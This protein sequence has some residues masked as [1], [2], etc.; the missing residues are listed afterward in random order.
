M[1]IDSDVPVWPPQGRQGTFAHAPPR[2]RDRARRRAEPGRPVWLPVLVLLALVLPDL[3]R[4][5]AAADSAGGVEVETLASLAT[6]ALPSPLFFGLAHLILPPGVASETA[7]T[8]G[9]RLFEVQAGS[10]TVE[11]AGGGVAF[12]AGTFGPT[13]TR[14]AI[15]VGE[16]V[17]LGRGDRLALGPH[18]VRRVRNDGARPVVYLDAALFSPGTEPVTAAFTTPDGITFQLLAGAIV[19]AIPTGAVEIALDRVSLAP[20]AELPT[21][22][23]LGAAIA[24]VES[25]SLWLVPTAGAVEYARAAAA[26]PS[27]TVGRMR[28]VALGAEVTMTAGASVVL[29]PG[30]AVA[31]RNGRNAPVTLLVLEVRPASP[32]ST[33]ATLPELPVAAP[34]CKVFKRG[35]DCP[36]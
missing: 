31:A 26:A 17:V 35:N 5:T 34:G 15:R 20:D 21:A 24:Y 29:P 19:A 16:E 3:G 30:S 22:A 1:Q 27:S 9:P 12:R 13:R 25:G 11:T 2:R 14:Q 23:R 36:R 10:L 6:E 28:P 18:A 7:N 8:A 4:A 33:A 32:S